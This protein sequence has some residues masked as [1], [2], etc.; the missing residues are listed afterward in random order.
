MCPFLLRES[1]NSSSSRPNLV[2]L[3][4]SRPSLLFL[5]T[6]YYFSI[7][8][9]LFASFP[10]PTSLCLIASLCFV[11]LVSFSFSPYLLTT[12][13]PNYR[14]IT[15]TVAQCSSFSVP[16]VASLSL[17]NLYCSFPFEENYPHSFLLASL[18]P[19]LNHFICFVHPFAA[20]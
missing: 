19:N 7:I 3:I 18:S 17:Q 16:S 2:Q 11:N 6:L 15:I 13:A 8:Y 4:H 10:S 9:F 12:S 20:I 5:C 14:A 1:S